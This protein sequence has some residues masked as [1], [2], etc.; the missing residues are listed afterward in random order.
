MYGVKSSVRNNVHFLGDHHVIYPC[1]HYVVIFCLD[2]K[3]QIFIPGIE[4]SEGITTL[5][6]SPS[7]RFLAVCEK[8]EHAICIIYD[9]YGV[10]T[11]KNGVYQYPKRKKVLT[12]HDC[13]AKEFVSACFSPHHEKITIATLTCPEHVKDT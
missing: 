4:G 8:S 2:D 10:T 3:S 7:K 5:A 11:P 1:G 9:L 13:S 6:I 12:S